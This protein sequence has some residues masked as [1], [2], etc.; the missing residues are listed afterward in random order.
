MRIGI[1]ARLLGEPRSGIGRYTGALLEALARLA[2]AE[3]WRLYVDRPGVAGPAGMTVRCLPWPQRLAWTLWAAPRALRADRLDLF[4][5]VTGF[6]LPRAGGARLVTTVHDLIPLRFPGLVPPRH[7]WAVRCLLPGAL[8]RARRVIAVSEATRAELLAR[9]PLPPAKVRVVPE[10]PAPAFRPVPPAVRAAVRARH[11]LRRPFVLFVGLLEPKKN[12]GALLGA[13]A[14]L[15]ARG[16]WG[17]TDLVLVGAAGWGPGSWAG[18]A[19]RLGVA[20]V[21]RFL[22][23]VADP[24]LAALY[25]EAS[26]FVFPSLWEGFGL[27]VVEAM[28]CGAPVLA[29]RRGALPEVAGDAALL[30]EPTAEALADGLGTLLA[31]RGLRER[32]GAAGLARAAAYSWEGTAGATLAVYREAAA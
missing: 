9:Y 8:R 14:R 17:P 11:G 12:P 23:P 2:P 6:E 20:D 5:G 21:A 28:A 15:R 30:V 24:E 22:G 29:S 32:L 16:A 31:D 4:H 26:V 27:P 7:R 25:A 18:E 13:V 3:D 1:D 10:A 19:A